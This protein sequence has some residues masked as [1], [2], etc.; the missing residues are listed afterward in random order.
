MLA[1][2]V[3]KFAE[4][5]SSPKFSGIGK[6]PEISISVQ[7]AFL[8]TGCTHAT[9]YKVLK[10]FLGIDAVSPPMFAYTIQLLHPVVS[11]M[12]EEL[13]AEAKLEMRNMD[14]SHAIHVW[15][16]QLSSCEVS[17]A[18]QRMCSREL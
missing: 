5:E 12:L 2:V 6:M 4:F 14:Q 10:N 7:V 1:M 11:K 15:I 13:C 18:N 8:V 16:Q 3:T 9:Y 17:A